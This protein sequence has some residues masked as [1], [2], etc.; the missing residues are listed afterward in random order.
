MFQK[1]NYLSFMINIIC[2]VLSRWVIFTVTYIIYIAS[3][4]SSGQPA[5][6]AK[7]VFMEKIKCSG[8]ELTLL[9]CTHN[10]NVQVKDHSKDVIMSCLQR[11]KCKSFS[12]IDTKT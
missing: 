12:I 11:K 2:S 4:K 6:G 10:S 5:T 3:Q 7:P 8:S 9:D 1:Y